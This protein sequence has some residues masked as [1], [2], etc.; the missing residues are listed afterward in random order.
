MAAQH[1]D[2]AVGLSNSNVLFACK[3]NLPSQ[4]VRFSLCVNACSLYSK[5]TPLYGVP[6]PNPSKWQ[7]FASII[8]H[9]LHHFLITIYLLL[10]QVLARSFAAPS[11][12]YYFGCKYTLL[13]IDCVLSL[14]LYPSHCRQI[15]PLLAVGCCTLGITRRICPIMLYFNLLDFSSQC[16]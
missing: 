4:Q 7:V 3:L 14:H 10:D 8:T 5:L 15:C 11:V 6:S 1:S 13:L 2:Q 12:S 9:F 16:P